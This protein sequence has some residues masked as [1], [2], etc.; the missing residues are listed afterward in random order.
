MKNKELIIVLNKG[1][2]TGLLDEEVYVYRYTN[3]L[4][5]VL[6]DNPLAIINKNVKTKLTTK[7]AEIIVGDKVTIVDTKSVKP[8]HLFEDISF[9]SIVDYDVINNNL[10][11]RVSA[12]ITPSM[13]VGDIII[14]YEFR[15]KMYQAKTIDF[16]TDIDKN[17]FY[18]PI[19]HSAVFH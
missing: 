13:V 15:N 11:V 16:I 17:P 3:G 19:K 7:K 9:G 14:T 2:G 12:T 5:D 4:I 10:M 18:G 6:V 8:S 1:Y